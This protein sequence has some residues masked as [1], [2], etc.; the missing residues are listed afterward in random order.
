MSGVDGGV[1]TIKCLQLQDKENYVLDK[2]LER[3]KRKTSKA[4]CKLRQSSSSYL[5]INYLKFVP[6]TLNVHLFALCLK[7]DK[8]TVKP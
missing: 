3:K 5:N 6:F 1:I 2:Y 8:Q 4:L 7:L